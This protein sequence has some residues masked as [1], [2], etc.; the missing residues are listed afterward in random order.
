MAAFV[1]ICE[2]SQIFSGQ[3]PD[4]TDAPC[5]P[6]LGAPTAAR[7]RGVFGALG[8]GGLMERDGDAFVALDSSGLLVWKGSKTVADSHLGGGGAQRDMA[9]CC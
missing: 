9:R 6:W 4:R 5:L 1:S 8:T 2:K 3:K 7:T